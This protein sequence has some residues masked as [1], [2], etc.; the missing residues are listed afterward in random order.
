MP[1][2]PLDTVGNFVFPSTSRE[3]EPS[4]QRL[5][6]LAHTIAV[7]Y[8]D[9]SRTLPAK[10]R[11]I[12]DIP[13]ASTNPIAQSLWS[14]ESPGETRIVRTHNWTDLDIYGVDFGPPSVD[15]GNENKPLVMHF[16]VPT[17]RVDSAGV[18]ILLLPA[19]PIS[20]EGGITAYVAGIATRNSDRLSQL[21]E[22][23]KA[24]LR[25]SVV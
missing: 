23:G 15:D 6:L 24:M 21:T 8:K 2:I 18:V 11:R 22:P 20:G 13:S 9:L 1:A 5:S 4:K 7:S 19:S 14:L 16:N 25:S 3:L 12:A 17:S 10:L